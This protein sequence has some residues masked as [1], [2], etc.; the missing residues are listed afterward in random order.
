MFL[1]ALIL[2]VSCEKSLLD[3]NESS[4]LQ[5]KE[6]NKI[7]NTFDYTIFNTLKQNSDLDNLLDILSDKEV[8]DMEAEEK[9]YSIL[10]TVNLYYGT[11]IEFP[12]EFH[13]ISDSSA[14]QILNVSETK[15][16][17]NQVDIDLINQ[18]EED[19]RNS[20]FNTAIANY[21][22]TV[23]SLKLD[24]EEFAKKNYVANS[25][26]TLNHHNPEILSRVDSCFGAIIGLIA[27]SAGILLCASVLA[28][29]FAIVGYTV[30]YANYM[31]QCGN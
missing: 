23:L 25:L 10:E 20:D 27:A 19:M 17:V 13:Q 31:D 28:C 29:G 12:N 7:G 18:F 11:D 8:G 24:N 14:E 3:A 30:A 16:W 4:T 22:N 21:E 2:F 9:S 6:F 15:G 5:N 26:K 1:S